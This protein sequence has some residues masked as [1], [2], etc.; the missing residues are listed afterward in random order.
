MESGG[1]AIL[2][3]VGTGLHLGDARLESSQCPSLSLPFPFCFHLRPWIIN[4]CSLIQ[5]HGGPPASFAVSGSS[6]SAQT[7]SRPKHG[8]SC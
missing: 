5:R 3:S 2:E 6:E 7:R 4:S 1:S 8:Y